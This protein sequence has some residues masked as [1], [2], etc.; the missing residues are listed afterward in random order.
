MDMQDNPEVIYR[1]LEKALDLILNLE[2]APAHRRALEQIADKYR[3]DALDMTPEEL[4]YEMMTRGRKIAIREA[5]QETRLYRTADHI[6]TTARIAI[7]KQL[8]RLAGDH[9]KGN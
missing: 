9:K 8:S 7:K 4:I 1:Q 5:R 3:D 2:P 6:A